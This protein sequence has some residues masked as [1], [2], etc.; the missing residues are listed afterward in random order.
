MI[1]EEDKGKL[2]SVLGHNYTI[3]VQDYLF[4]MGH[5]N[6][7]GKP[8]TQTHIRQVMN[9]YQSHKVIEDAIYAVA[10]SEEQNVKKKKQQLE[11]IAS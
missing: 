6:T 7:H 1:T 2:K 11:K 5:R 10:E 8:F 9:G 4:K 3:S